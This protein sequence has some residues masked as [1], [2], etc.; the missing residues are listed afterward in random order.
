M[1]KMFSE[2]LKIDAEQIKVLKNLSKKEILSLLET[3]VK[4][5]EQFS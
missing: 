2:D 4:D 1:A 5:V 3:L